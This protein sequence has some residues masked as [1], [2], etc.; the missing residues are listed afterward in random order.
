MKHAQAEPQRL[1][2]AN[3]LALGRLNA[4]N[5]M[6]APD[7][8]MQAATLDRDVAYVAIDGSGS[9]LFQDDSDEQITLELVGGTTIALAA[10]TQRE[11][12]AGP[13]GLQFTTVHLRRDQLDVG[14]VTR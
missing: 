7:A 6:L 1:P 11:L 2:G 13:R 5:V 12:V 14:K 4:T 3:G 10:G 8:H 9:L